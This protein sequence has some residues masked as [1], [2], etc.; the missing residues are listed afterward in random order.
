MET[1]NSDYQLPQNFLDYILPYIRKDEPQAIGDRHSLLQLWQRALQAKQAFPEAQESIAEWTVS[2]AATSPVLADDAYLQ[3]HH[4]FAA[5]E[6]MG[7]GDTPDRIAESW[8]ALTR[9]VEELA[10]AYT[11]KKPR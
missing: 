11:N 4:A 10:A 2:A 9:E 1:F 3:V 5:L 6:D 7:A 8:R